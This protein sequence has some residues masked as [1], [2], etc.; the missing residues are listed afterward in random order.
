VEDAILANDHGAG[1]GPGTVEPKP[2]D[3]D[4]VIKIVGQDFD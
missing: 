4:A 2:A 3:Q 1:A